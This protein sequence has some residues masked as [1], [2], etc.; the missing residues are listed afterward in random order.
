MTDPIAD[1]IGDYRAFTALQ[2]DR[3]AARD[4]D[5]RRTS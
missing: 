1:L 4:I 5:S 2:R 3:L